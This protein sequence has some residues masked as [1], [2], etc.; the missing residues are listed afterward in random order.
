MQAQWRSHWQQQIYLSKKSAST[1]IQAA[2][3]CWRGQR[4]YAR[5]RR[6]AIIV[7]VVLSLCPTK[8]DFHSDQLACRFLLAW[9]GIALG[10]VLTISQPFE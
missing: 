10:I 4:G 6:A 8:T 7:Q 5:L 2:F 1:C 9:E 3:R